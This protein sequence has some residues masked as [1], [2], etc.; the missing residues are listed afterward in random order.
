M[1]NRRV[2]ILLR[3]LRLAC[4][5]W[6]PLGTLITGLHSELRDHSLNLNAGEDFCFQ[7]SACP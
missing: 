3:V 2:P 1:F 5:T 6:P 7:D 4:Q